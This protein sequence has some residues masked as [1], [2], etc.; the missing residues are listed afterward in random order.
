[1]NWKPA[2]FFLTISKDDVIYL[3]D[4][5]VIEFFPPNKNIYFQ[6]EN[7][8]HVYFILDG[9]VSISYK[10][11]SNC[12]DIVSEYENMLEEDIVYLSTGQLFG[13]LSVILYSNRIF[14]AKSMTFTYVLKIKS[15]YF[16][17]FNKQKKNI[18]KTK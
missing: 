9:T 17:V 6:E 5:S 10:T 4:N 14:N 2:K 15:E 8:D 3:I 13:E 11:K 18:S 16:F 7:P 12:N 1:M